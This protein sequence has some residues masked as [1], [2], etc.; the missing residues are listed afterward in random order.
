MRS[1]HESGASMSKSEAQAKPKDRCGYRGWT[2]GNIHTDGVVKC[3]HSPFSSAKLATYPQPV[4]WPRLGDFHGAKALV[5]AIMDKDIVAIDRLGAQFPEHDFGCGEW[6][7]N[8]KAEY[9][10]QTG[11]KRKILKK[12]EL[13]NGRTLTLELVTDADTGQRRITSAFYRGRTRLA[14]KTVVTDTQE[15]THV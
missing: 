12:R 14:E 13:A 15:K 10:R 9:V 1:P 7:K 8:L 3:W 4:Y 6:G 2:I 5:D 11:L